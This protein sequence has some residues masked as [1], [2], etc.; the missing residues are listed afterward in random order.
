MPTV[1]LVTA[2]LAVHD[3]E[4]YVGTALES[5]LRQTVSRSRAD[6]RRRCVDRRDAG[7]ARRPRRRAAARPPERRAARPRCVAQPRAGR[8]ARARTSPDSTPTTSR[9]PRRLERQLAPD[10][11]AAVRGGR[12]L[13]RRSSSTS[14]GGSGAR[15]RCRP[16]AAAVRWAAL[17]SSPFFHPTVLVERDVL[18]RHGLRY[19]PSFAESEDYD[20]WSRLLDVADGDNLPEP[21]VLYRV[22]S[23]SGV[24]AAPRAPARVSAAASRDGRSQRVAPSSRPAEVELAW[25]VGVAEPIDPGEAEAGRRRISRAR[26]H[27][28]EHAAGRG[29]RAIARPV[30]ARARAPRERRSSPCARILPAGAPARS[31]A[32][33]SHAVGATPRRRRAS[34]TRVAARSGGLAAP[35]RRR[36]SPRAIRVAAVFPEPTPYRAPL[37]DR[38]AASSRDRPD[39]DLRGRHRRRSDVAR[40]AEAPRRLPPRRARPRRTSSVLHHDYP[41]TPGVVRALTEARPDVVVVSGWSTFAAQAAIAWCRLEGRPVPA[42]RR[43]P[44]RGSACRLAADG[45][46]HRRPAGR[47]ARRRAS[48][49]RGRSRATR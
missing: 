35:A 17:F 4:A 22:H 38:V 8:G 3:G 45:E 39:G 34:P 10:S 47:R 40:R 28:F 36:R 9:M 49:S 41:L 24:A 16:G 12:R 46:G 30:D 18:E 21:L 32:S 7:D 31:R 13:G 5:M 33:A 37:L 6:R 14:S 48:S 2:L 42:R 43:E 23:A 25:R 15:T 29:A 26:S 44:R 19:D 27:A 1:P 11:R 20:L